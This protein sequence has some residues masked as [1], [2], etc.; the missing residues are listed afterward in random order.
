MNFSNKF[1]CECREMSTY[2][3]H[4]A[5]PL[6][7]RSFTVKGKPEKAD[8]IL[9]GLG[10]Y[11]LYINGNRITK[12]RLSPYISNPD[13][14]YYYD[15]Y[16]LTSYLN[17]GENVIGIM[18]GDG[19]LNAKCPV[20][21]FDKNSF[22]SSPKLALEFLLKDESGEQ[23]LN[24]NDFHCKKGPV[25]FNDLRSG[26]FFDKRLEEKGWFNV[27]FCEDDKWHTPL[28]ADTPKGEARL[29][30]A[31][32]IAVQREISPVSFY[33]GELS[34]DYPLDGHYSPDIKTAEAPMARTGGWIYDF[35][36]NNAGIFRLKIKGKRGQRIDIQCAEKIT[37]GK[38]DYSNLCFYPDGYAQRDI[39]IVGS[40]EEEIYEPF[41]TYH[42]FRY[43]YIT[44]I[45]EEQATEAL[46]TYL[47]MCS[48][49]RTIGAFNCSDDTANEIFAM[50]SRSDF[51]N[52]YYFPTDCPHREKNGWTGD[53]A[54]SAEHMTLTMDVEKSYTEWLRNISAAQ[55]GDGKIPC[56]VPTGSWGYG[57]GSGP[58]WDTVIFTLP[59]MLYR[60]RGNTEVISENAHT[61][62]SYLHYISACRN[63]K[64]LLELG[65]GD[66]CPV[67]RGSSE[68]Q[69]PLEFTDSVMT[70]DMCRMA[71][72][73]FKATGMREN[74]KYAQQ[75]GLD[76]YNRIRDEY[77]E[78]DTVAVKG[79]CQSAQAIGIAY[80]I[81]TEKEKPAAFDRLLDYIH[82]NGDKI[83]TGFLGLR[84]IFNVLADYGEAEL[85]WKMIVGKDFPAY[86][87][88][89]KNGYTTLPEHFTTD[90]RGKSLNHHFFG[91]VKQWLI[92]YA[93]GLRV[94]NHNTVVIKPCF[95]KE[96]NF[97]AARHTL[98]EGE[99]AVFWERKS[100]EIALKIICPK[101]IKCTVVEDKE[102]GPLSISKIIA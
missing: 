53:A 95:L 28:A 37:N 83:D 94:E 14:I 84:V 80:G 20:W 89:V 30:E 54:V 26:E 77:I 15:R 29:C 7:R 81:F 43:I 82:S 69:A 72:T 86:G 27:G 73:M 64:G 46:L 34:D 98:P 8:L 12:G 60:Y 13:H 58:A 17:T 11:E 23:A 62:I 52:F 93:A 3:K 31:E 35:G 4:I 88:Y 19:F 36:E 96:L 10:L 51:S 66:W 1:V 78:P 47:V 71:A 2:G 44:G 57:W 22:S 92:R 40:N 38:V 59:Y 85:A 70:Y 74:E 24:A 68:Y 5:A 21:D 102:H 79:H 6:F 91:D 39:Y 42:G 55:R 75:L 48:D 49:L 33:K 61:M 67:N 65:L 41:F 63:K 9:C 97:A 50:A 56:I 87:W 25:A 100:K 90:M 18:L 76:L 16:N 99:V 32:P 101:N 45:T